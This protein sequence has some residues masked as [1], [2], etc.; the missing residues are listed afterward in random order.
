MGKQLAPLSKAAG[1]ARRKQI[2]DN[3][4]QQSEKGTQVIVKRP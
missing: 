1:V 2:Q 4:Q 3:K